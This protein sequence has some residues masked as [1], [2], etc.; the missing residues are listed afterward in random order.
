MSAL[1]TNVDFEHQENM[2]LLKKNKPVQ[3]E[4]YVGT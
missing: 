1:S 2:V 4:Y 3:I